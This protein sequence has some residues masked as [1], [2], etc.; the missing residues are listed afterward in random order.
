MNKFKLVKIINSALLASFLIQA[1]TSIVIFFQLSEDRIIYQTHK[2]N[3]LL[4]V[5]LAIS[6]IAFNWGW[7]RVTFFK[8]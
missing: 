5:I 3:G 4:M 2:Y 7:V 6:H 8:K 1:F